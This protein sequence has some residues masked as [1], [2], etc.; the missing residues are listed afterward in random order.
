MKRFVGLMV[1]LVLACGLL[2]A[3]AAGGIATTEETWYV[4]PHSE[5]WRVYFYA[6]VENSGSAPETVNNLLFEIVSPDGTAIDSTAKYKLYPE[7][8]QPGETGWLVISKDVKDVERADISAYNLTVT[9]KTDDDRAARELDAAAEFLKKDEDD[10]ENMLRAAVTNSGDENA[11]ELT[12]AM[13]AR[14]AE[15]KL[16]YVDGVDTK[17]VGL[18]QGG[19]LLV[20]AAIASDIVDALKDAGAEVASVDAVAYAMVDLDD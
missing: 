7:V 4:A 2:P 12:V 18:A 16:L 11:F 19:S 14:D 9:S 15:G 1:A 17:D 8:L 3:Y 13:A 5:N 20:R 10:N 6:T